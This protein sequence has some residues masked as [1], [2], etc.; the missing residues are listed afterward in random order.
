MTQIVGN[1]TRALN[2]G[3]SPVVR[4]HR[5]PWAQGIVFAR[6]S[7]VGR[8]RPIARYGPAFEE[9][10]DYSPGV[11]DQASVTTPSRPGPHPAPPVRYVH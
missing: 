10:P 1:L 8:H 4:K 2:H 6:A 7:A 11:R 9:A 5:L 3:Y